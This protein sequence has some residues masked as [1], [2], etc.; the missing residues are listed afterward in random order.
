MNGFEPLFWMGAVLTFIRIVRTGN[1][2]LW[3]IFGIIAGLGLQNK[4]SMAFFGIAIVIGLLAGVHK[5]MI[6]SK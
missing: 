4:H 2:K 5:R 3:L 6:L 1:Q